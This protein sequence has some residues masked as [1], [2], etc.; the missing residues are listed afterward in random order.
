MNNRILLAFLLTAFA[1]LSTGIGGLSAFIRGGE[2]RGFLAGSLGFS[3]GV[4]IYISFVELFPQAG[5]L[6]AEGCGESAGAWITI[7]G[8]FGGMLLIGLIDFFVPSEMNPHVVSTGPEEAKL[9]DKL[10]LTRIGLLTS[11]AIAIHN[12]PEGAATFFATLT[13]PRIGFSIAVAVAIHNI[14]EGISVAVPVYHATGSRK[15]A[16]AYAFL[17]GL[18]EPIGAL[19]A[20]WL[21]RPYLS[22]A[23]MGVTFAAIAGIMVF[24][25]LDQL[26]PNAKRYDEGHE[27]V[28]GLVG[29]MLVMAISL[30]LL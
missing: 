2:R 13:D 24:V 22:P 25:S 9:R 3:A 15:K 20:Y 12:F 29:G 19:A 14:P 18:A 16:L 17:S 5:R 28:Y 1:G 10:H 26:I 27:S 6:L 8:F 7:A 21:L 23:V 30:E 11:L 4:M